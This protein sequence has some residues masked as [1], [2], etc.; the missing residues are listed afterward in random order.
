M[1]NDVKIFVDIVKFKWIYTSST[2][3][4]TTTDNSSNCCLWWHRHGILHLLPAFH[5]RTVIMVIID[6]YTKAAH[7]DTLPDKFFACQA[8]EFFTTMFCKFRRFWRS[9]ISDIDPIF[10]SKFWRTLLHLHAL[11]YAWVQLTILRRTDKMRYWIGIFSNIWGHSYIKNQ[12]T[13]KSTYIRQ[14]GVTTRWNAVLFVLHPFK[15]FMANHL[16]QYLLIY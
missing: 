1:R 2:D 14:N 12:N 15:W 4:P 7:F 13:G 5:E 6:K 9:I 10:L 8:I 3:A 11:D 16:H